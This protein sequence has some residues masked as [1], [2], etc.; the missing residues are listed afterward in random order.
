MAEMRFSIPVL[1]TCCSAD[2]E[3]LATENEEDEAAGKAT[4]DEEADA[5]ED[6]VTDEEENVGWDS[7]VEDEDPLFKTLR[8]TSMQ[9]VQLDSDFCSCQMDG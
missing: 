9:D 5:D 2:A 8:K 4:W 3:R 7:L 6:V 1:N